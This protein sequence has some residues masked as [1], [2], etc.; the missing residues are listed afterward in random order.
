MKMEYEDLARLKID[1]QTK[2]DRNFLELAILFDKPEFLEYLPKIRKKYSIN[3]LHRLEEY[4]QL[5]D[6]YFKSEE[7]KF[8]F[9][10]YENAK[11]LIEYAN[12]NVVWYEE[13]ED[14]EM[15]LHQQL[16]TDASILCYLFRRPPYF[17]EPIK[18]A[19]LTDDSTVSKILGN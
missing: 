19:I 11:E 1:I 8:D 12:K 5:I 14:A 10:T 17:A 2:N 4:E 13:I 6:K 15:T 16:D 9:S 18:Q 7:S 3:S